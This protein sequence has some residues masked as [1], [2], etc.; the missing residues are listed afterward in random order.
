MDA[1]VVVFLV[2]LVLL[3]ALFGKV[4]EL[5]WAI[6]LPI[7]GAMGIDRVGA[8]AVVNVVTLRVTVAICYL[9]GL[10]ATSERG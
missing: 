10:A 7:T 9:A 6:A 4:Y 3:L 1:G 8:V 2:P 5:T